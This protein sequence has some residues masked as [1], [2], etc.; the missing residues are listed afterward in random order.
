MG[1]IKNKTLHVAI[2]GDICMSDLPYK[3]NR[4]LTRAVLSKMQPVLNSADVRVINLEN[5]IID[6]GIAIKKSGPSLKAKPNDLVF[7]QEGRFDCAILANNHVGDY[8]EEGIYSTLVS[9]DKRNIGHVGAGCN[10]NDSYEPWYYDTEGGKLAII[11]VCENE[12]GIAEENKAGTAGF[13]M[14]RVLHTI[15]AAKTNAD[16]VIVVVH[17][18]NEEN[19]LPSPGVVSRYRTIADIGADTVIGMHPHC[20]QGFEIYNNVPIVYSTGNFLFSD[21]NIKDPQ[22]PWYYGYIPYL[23]YT[24]GLPVTL[25]IIPYRFDIDCMMISPFEGEERNIMLKYID[26]ISA[27]IKN[28]SSLLQYFKGWCIISGIK[29]SKMIN[30]CPE[31]FDDPDYPTELSLLR[32]KNIFTCEAHNELMTEFFKMVVNKE[33]TIGYSM[34]DKLK[35]LQ[36]MPI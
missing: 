17:G 6:G 5:A 16:F 18:G 29:H 21:P 27:V 30:Y 35:G 13:D 25:E 22:N 4:E 20:I 33:Q 23:T 28:P 26:K 24:K 10:I 31:R 15:R 8:G 3:I 32:L 34:V 11:A 2:A 36:K 14:Y 9:L 12:Y 1:Y 19:P 7:L